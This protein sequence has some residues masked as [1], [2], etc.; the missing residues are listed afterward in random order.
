M[1]LCTDLNTAEYYFKDR[2]KGELATMQLSASK[3]KSSLHINR[4]SR[5][6]LAMVLSIALMLLLVFLLAY[7]VG[8]REPS[9]EQLL[10]DVQPSSL[11]EN[12]LITTTVTLQH[13]SFIVVH[14]ETGVKVVLT[15]LSLP[16]GSKINV[17]SIYYG[18]VSPQQTQTISLNGLAF[19]DVKVTLFNGE[20]IDSEA[21]VLVY[22]SN[23][24]FN[25]ADKLFYWTVSA[26]A[27]VNTQIVETDT[28]S[29][30]FMVSQLGGTLIGVS[31]PEVFVVPEMPLG[32]LF[33]VLACLAG[34]TLLHRI[35]KK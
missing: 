19:Y 32:S 22:I 30:T 20:T 29:G 2:R 3:P 27:P 1:Q 35:H 24:L 26:W 31:A 4:S 13:G 12:T 5:K 8:S 10:P 21:N 6:R 25:Q 28:L 15:G 34:Y 9:S 33:A 16:D 18:S 17:T 11:L 7:Y 14:T 23:P